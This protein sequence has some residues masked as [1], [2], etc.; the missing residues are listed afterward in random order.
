MVAQLGLVAN[1]YRDPH[2]YFAFQPFN[3][4]STYAVE[5]WGDGSTGRPGSTSPRFD[6]TVVPEASWRMVDRDGTVLE[7][8]EA[9]QFVRTRLPATFLFS[10]FW[11]Y[12]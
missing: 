7:G 5:L 3:E 4:S 10:R 6:I 9:R 8:R 11:R 2:N 1:G 12:S